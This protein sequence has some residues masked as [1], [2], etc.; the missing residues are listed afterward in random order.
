MYGTKFT[1]HSIKGYIPIAVINI[2]GV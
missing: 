1:V 2:N